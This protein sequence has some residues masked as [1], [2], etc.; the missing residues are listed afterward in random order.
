MKRHLCFG[1]FRRLTTPFFYPFLHIPAD[2]ACSM[3]TGIVDLPRSYL[4]PA[5]VLGEPHSNE[6]QLNSDD[7]LHVQNSLPKVK[8]EIRIRWS[9]Q[10]RSVKNENGHAENSS[11]QKPRKNN[12]KM[13]P[14]H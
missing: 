10:S 8:I 12:L 5:V 7:W 13:P 2:Y 9:C 1:G 6:T 11:M 3:Y 14:R 4:R